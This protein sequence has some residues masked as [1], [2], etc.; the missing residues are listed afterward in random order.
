[1]MADH[2]IFTGNGFVNLR[3]V[4]SARRNGN[5]RY[6]LL[7]GDTVLDDNN[8]SFDE[9]LVSIIPSQ[10]EWECLTLCTEEDGSESVVVEVVVAF[11]LTVFGEIRPLIPSAMKG[12]VGAYM[13]RREGRT[14]IAGPGGTFKDEAEWLRSVTAP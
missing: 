13:L 4:D 11:G 2:F 5:G 12:E 10:G 9:T 1:M 7:E 8:P 6:T 14:E 3:R